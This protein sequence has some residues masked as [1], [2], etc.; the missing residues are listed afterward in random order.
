VRRGTRHKRVVDGGRLSS[1]RGRYTLIVIATGADGQTARETA[2][3]TVRPAACADGADNDKDGLID[4][5]DPGCSS[6]RDHDETNPAAVAACA[7]GRENDADGLTDLDDPGCESASDEDESN[8]L[9]ACSDGVDNDSDGLI[10]MDDPGC[11]DPSDAGE[12][13]RG[14]G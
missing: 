2:T 8:P 13:N 12:F 5:R 1:R 4:L 6:V 14:V 3:Y 7:D 10:D 9:P 11:A